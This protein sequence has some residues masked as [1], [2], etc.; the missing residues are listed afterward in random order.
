MA[1]GNRKTLLPDSLV[2]WHRPGV[3]LAPST[4]PKIPES[5]ED[6]KTEVHN[7]KKH[8]LEKRLRKTNNATE[9]RVQELSLRRE[10][11]AQKY[12]TCHKFNQAGVGWISFESKAGLEMV[13]IK[14]ARSEPKGRKVR[15]QETDHV[16]VVN[17]IEAFLF[18][19]TTWLV[20]SFN[21]FDI[22]LSVLCA[23]PNLEMGEA[24]I[25][26]ICRDILKG[27]QY[28]HTE[29]KLSHGSINRKNILFSHSGQ[30]KIGEYWR[31]S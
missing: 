18:N 3:P 15:L 6:V 4:L 20:Y 19:Q 2:D 23:T 26:T 24:D 14:A 1:L 11:P 10:S 13:F 27:L 21:P 7:P 9:S 12:W 8:V 30:I 31:P 29:L 22:S 28:I 16:N 25:A 17:L 5:E